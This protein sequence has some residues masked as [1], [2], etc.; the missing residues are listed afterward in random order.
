MAIGKRVFLYVDG[1]FAKDG[2]ILLLK[3]NVE[4]FK[5]FWALVG[6]FIEENE[7]P[8]EALCR[9][10]KEETNLDVNVGEFLSE[11]FEEFSDRIKR[12]LTFRITSAEGEVELNEENQE[13]GWFTRVPEKAVYR[14][15]KFLIK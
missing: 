6:G 5:G 1:F 12:I 8:Q 13:F 7:T 15:E 3:R 9:E 11:R 10:F 14:Y 2:E 4:P